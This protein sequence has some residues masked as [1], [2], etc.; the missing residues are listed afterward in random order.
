MVLQL[1]A[2]LLVTIAAGA[3][4]HSGREG[5]LDVA[6]PR[7]E[8][9]VEIDGRLDEP[10]W[11][12]AATLTGFSQYAPI[13][14]QPAA[15]DTSVLAWYS[16]TAIH[17]G[18][19]ASA[20]AGS[21]RATLADRDRLDTEDQIQIFLSTFN[22][23]RQA[24][25]FAVNPLGVQADGALTEGTQGVSRGFDGLGTGREDV[26]LSPDFVYE[27]K[28]HVT[29]AGYDV[30]VRIPFKSLRYQSAN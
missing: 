11:A 12:Q 13:D 14:G 22:D 3:P 19:R 10:A 18:V 7:L 26:D 16:P 24:F 8:A 2:G 23:G 27:S 20:A 25:M 30:E 9:A 6:V 21:V 5:S 15:Q 1:F 29:E 17:F 4:E 28:G